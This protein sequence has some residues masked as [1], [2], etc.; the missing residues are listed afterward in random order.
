MKKAVHSTTVHTVVAE[1]HPKVLKNTVPITV[2]KILLC[3]TLEAGPRK[4]ITEIAHYRP[5]DTSAV[6]YAVVTEY[7]GSCFQC[8]KHVQQ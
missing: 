6:Q 5:N 3:D 1:S 4:K 7:R 8:Q 2:R